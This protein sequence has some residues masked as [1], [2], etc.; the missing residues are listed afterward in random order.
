MRKY[1][2]YTLTILLTTLA[3]FANDTR[4]I[5][6]L[7]NCSSYSE[8]GTVNTDGME[9]KAHKQI[10]GWENNK[11]V[12]KENLQFS[13]VN[14][15]VVCRFTKPQINEIS[16][17]MQAYETVMEYSDQKVDTSSPEAVQNNPVVKVWN[18]Y[19]QDSS[20]CTMSGLEQKN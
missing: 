15:D 7:R 3:V 4:F 9:V 17:V 2:V 10:L 18:K 14:T 8:F 6:S 1:L 11:C 13:G 19:L 16:S 20:V 5:N 12:Y